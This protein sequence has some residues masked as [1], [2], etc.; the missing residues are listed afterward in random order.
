MNRRERSRLLR[1]DR[2]RQIQ[3]GPLYLAAI[4]GSVPVT[5]EAVCVNELGLLTFIGVGVDR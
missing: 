5:T 3:I 1:S 4:S 2:E